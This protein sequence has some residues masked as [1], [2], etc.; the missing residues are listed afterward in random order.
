M[1][2]ITFGGLSSGLDTTSLIEQ[3]VSVER[4]AATRVTTRKSNID[5]QKSIISSLSSS[6]STLATAARGL[7]LDSEVK[8]RAVSVSDS[9]VAVAV[10]ST[11]SAGVH[12]FR[13]TSLAAAQVT[14]SRAFTGA[15]AGVAGA[16]GLDITVGGSTKSI[17]WTATDSLDAIATKINSA[18]AKV[19]ASVL[20][21]DDTNY[22]L[23][24]SAKE[25]GTA[26]APT[27]VE[28]GD[29]LGLTDPLNVKVAA[30]NAVVN[31]DGIDIIRSSNVISDALSGMT[32]TLANKH[33]AADPTTKATVTLDTTA[34]T[35]RVKKVIDAF[36]TVNAALHVQLDYTG[37]KKGESTLF[38]DSTLRQLQT[39]IGAIAS[40]AYGETNIAAV[41]IT[42]DRTGTMTLD[43]AKLTDAI[44]KDPEAVA[45]L[46][47][48]GGFANAI[49]TLTDQYT[50]ATDG[51]LATKS[52]A[53][54]D[55]Q[56]ILQD[57]IDRINAKADELD[58]RLTAQFAALETAM[59][60]LRSQSS[61]LS[62]F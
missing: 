9:R 16:G 34:L 23:V 15:A 18:D 25:S 47:V 31:V 46:F 39:S 62:A 30:S 40:A 2:A 6:L 48:T 33:E 27:F 51:V 4:A 10:S 29:P 45:K 58:T 36:N 24:V 11:A 22:R 21:V 26:N 1:P 28:T 37:T 53:L 60:K 61:Y 50:R 8:P 3:L 20:R 49:A 56:K 43:S 17:T 59:T 38:G 57:Q 55:R 13:V 54:T 32:L 14:Q 44:G 35:E 12:E 41:G 19:N 5:T 42:R 7:D 52:Q